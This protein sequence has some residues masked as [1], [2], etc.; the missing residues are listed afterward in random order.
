MESISIELNS[1]VSNTVQSNGEQTVATPPAEE[2]LDLRMKTSNH[3]IVAQQFTVPV[4]NYSSSA[5]RN[6]FNNICLNWLL[7]QCCVASTSLAITHQTQSGSTTAVNVPTEVPPLS[8]ANSDN[9][10][11]NKQRGRVARNN[12]KPGENKL[13]DKI[14]VG[15]DI[16]FFGMFR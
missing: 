3:E 4:H 6:L 12:Y 5:M 11:G 16:S 2:P 13:I 7:S 10:R 9:Q 8:S 15:Y 1:S 14:K